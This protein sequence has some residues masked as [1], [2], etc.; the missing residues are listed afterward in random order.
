MKV[1]NNKLKKSNTF[2]PGPGNICL[3]NSQGFKNNDVKKLIHDEFLPI[4][5]L[6]EL[7]NKN[8]LYD[9]KHLCCLLEILFRYSRYTNDIN[10]F[11]TYDTIWL[12]Y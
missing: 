4:Y 8:D 6:F 12:K 1:V 11:Y 9:K 3:D 10:T 7:K 2:P 5:E